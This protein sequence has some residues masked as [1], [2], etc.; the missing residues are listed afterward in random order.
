MLLH[1]LLMWL[2]LA[3]LAVLGTIDLP[4]TCDVITK[5]FTQLIIEI[6]YHPGASIF[7][8][9]MMLVMELLSIAVLIIILTSFTLLFTTLSKNKLGYISGAAFIPLAAFLLADYLFFAKDFGL[10]SPFLIGIIVTYPY[11]LGTKGHRPILKPVVIA[12]IIATLLSVIIEFAVEQYADYQEEQFQNKTSAEHNQDVIDLYKEY[13]NVDIAP[14]LELLNKGTGNQ[15]VKLSK[16]GEVLPADASEWACVWDQ[17]SQRVWEVKTTDG[18]IQDAQNR[19]SFGGQTESS[20]SIEK[21]RMDFVFRHLTSKGFSLHQDKARSKSI[22]A[23]WNKLVDE[24]N[25]QRLCGLSSWRVPNV[26]EAVSLHNAF[27]DGLDRF[28]TD[29]VWDLPGS[30]YVKTHL[31]P[32]FFPHAHT[33]MWTNTIDGHLTHKGVS[34]IFRQQKDDRDIVKLISTDEKLLVRLISDVSMSD[35]EN[36]KKENHQKQVVKTIQ[37]QD[38]EVKNIPEAKSETGLITKDKTESEIQ[39]TPHHPGAASAER[40]FSEGSQAFQ[41][42]AKK[43]NTAPRSTPVITDSTSKRDYI[44]NEGLV[45]DRDNNMMWMRCSIGQ[46]WNG[47]ICT[48]TATSLT[49][50]EAENLAQAQF[51]GGYSDWRLPNVHELESLIYCSNGIDARRYDLNLGCDDKQNKSSYLIPT[52]LHDVFPA[53]Q[54]PKY[55][56]YWSTSESK[57]SPGWTLLISFDRGT[58]NITNRNSDKRHVRLIRGSD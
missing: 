18:G 38:V 5:G 20:L 8:M 51:Y 27:S 30:D 45:I 1:G 22:E 21:N 54:Y 24:L 44:T 9:A 16:T 57:A 47:N 35:S 42:A 48:G 26:F 31:N 55:N 7:V 39:E 46:A 23:S 33:R 25:K 19:Y 58:A 52:Y 12:T 53:E 36:K 29:N 28:Y 4:G 40:V 17:N 10:L 13:D 6:G 49:K 41:D 56:N 11:W 34:V 43:V 50:Q 14:V 32:L 37:K 3:V 15:F 2:V